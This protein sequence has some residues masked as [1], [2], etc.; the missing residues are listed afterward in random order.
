MA[1]LEELDSDSGASPGKDLEDKNGFA[2]FRE[3]IL[4]VFNEEF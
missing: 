3:K 1:E 2:S 4:L